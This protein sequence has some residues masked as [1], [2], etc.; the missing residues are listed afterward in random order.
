M[1]QNPGEYQEA[2]YTVSLAARSRKVSNLVSLTQ[3]QETP[4]VKI[5]M[6]AKLQ[7]WLESKGKI[8]SSQ[9]KDA[10]S[11]PF[12]LKSPSNRSCMNKQA[13]L[14]SSVKE[15]SA[16]QRITITDR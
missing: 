1:L 2:V 12:H 3:K 9:R 16:R 11:S 14:H 7:A 5:D 15:K 6:E 8:R 13:V 4:K 10:F